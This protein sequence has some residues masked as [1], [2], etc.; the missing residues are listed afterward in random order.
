MTWICADCNSNNEDSAVE[1]EVCGGTTHAVI[2]KAVVEKLTLTPAK[3]KALP[4]AGGGVVYVPGEYT[5]IGAHAFEGRIFLRKIVLH[6]EVTHINKHAFKNCYALTAVV[7]YERL[8]RI[9]EEAFYNCKSLVERPTAK[10][11][12]S[13]AFATGPADGASTKPKTTSSTSASTS[14]YRPSS[15]AGTS[16]SRST[17]TSRTTSTSTSSSSTTVRTTVSSTGGSA[18][19]R[20]SS[21]AGTSSYRPSS[22]A[23]TSTY[24]PTTSTTTSTYRPSSTAGTSTYRPTTTTSAST[25]RPT[26]TTSASTTRP[27]TT[28]STT[29]SRPS[30]TTTTTTR[31][32]MTVA[33]A[34]RKVCTDKK[35]TA[36]ER[37]WMTSTSTSV[38][39]DS[40]ADATKIRELTKLLRGFRLKNA[41]Q[42]LLAVLWLALTLYMTF[43]VASSPISYVC[44]WSASAL[45]F[46]LVS[47][48][49]QALA[50]HKKD[51]AKVNWMIAGAFVANFVLVVNCA[52]AMAFADYFSS[53]AIL[54]TLLLFP[55]GVALSVQGFVNK[56]KQLGVFHIF[57]AIMSAFA[58][59]LAGLFHQADSNY[60]FE[61]LVM[62]GGQITQ[63]IMAVQTCKEEWDFDATGFRAQTV[64]SALAMVVMALSMAIGGNV[65]TF[66]AVILVGVVAYSISWAVAGIRYPIEYMG[67]YVATAV[68]TVVAIVTW[69]FLTYLNQ[70]QV[71]SWQT[72]Q[73]AYGVFFALMLHN[74]V[75]P[76]TL[77]LVNGRYGL[78]YKER[79]SLI[80]AILFAISA[81]NVALLMV[82]RQHYLVVFALI[83]VAIVKCFVVAVVYLNQDSHEFAVLAIVSNCV[84]FVAH[85]GAVVLLLFASFELANWVLACVLG[86]LVFA[87]IGWLW[88]SAE[89]FDTVSAKLAH[90]PQLALA[91]VAYLLYF[92]CKATG[93]VVLPLL[94]ATVASAIVTIVLATKEGD[95]K[96]EIATSSLCIVS[97]VVLL[98]FV[99]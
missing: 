32:T 44:I 12:A 18:T 26:T 31:G 74:V 94:L 13:N 59:M 11:V 67:R 45:S 91:V 17:S 48:T 60:A 27:S 4:M 71:A 76:L 23:G 99:L 77:A 36:W 8:E 37:K 75:E 69:F 52:L 56:I 80:P 24:R 89:D 43:A 33:E 57:T 51:D 83:A 1:C 66:S 88:I 86:V 19:Y 16:T 21:T 14:T 22:T 97:Q 96:K 5:V 41:V 9:G 93:F 85:V 95:C 79:T 62:V 73:W 29:A 61:L 46:A 81:I 87:T 30:T 63:V 7:G 54:L 6:S 90:A 58:V 35:A 28:A 15:T 3:A 72:L 64:L 40:T 20:P 2:E 25:Y 78:T 47:T 84:A 53:F 42:G 38:V 34:T 55:A 65:S 39:L 98:L 68:T 49:F 50:T 70:A 92:A 10:S 82:F